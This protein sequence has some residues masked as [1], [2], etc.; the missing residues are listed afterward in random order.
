M[1]GSSSHNITLIQ[2]VAC[3]STT[4]ATRTGSGWAVYHL[5][6]SPHRHL[7][8]PLLLLHLL[9][10]IRYTSCYCSNGLMHNAWTF[11][12]TWSVNFNLLSPP[13]QEMLASAQKILDNAES[14][15]VYTCMLNWSQ[16]LLLLYCVS[17]LAIVRVYISEW[18]ITCAFWQA[19]VVFIAQ[20]RTGVAGRKHCRQNYPYS[21]STLYA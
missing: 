19:E 14:T 13:P 6:K 12:R 2:R 8:L 4:I 9:L 11:V 18:S 10:A 21:H 7:P 15:K 1:A 3:S 20:W 17:F 5:T 16:V